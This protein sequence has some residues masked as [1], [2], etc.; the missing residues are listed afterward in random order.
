MKLLIWYWGRKGGGAKYS[1]EIAKSFINI[2]KE[3]TFLSF[4]KQ[5]EV[6]NNVDKLTQN[7]LHIKTYEN[8]LQFIIQTMLLPILI[9]RFIYFIRKNKIDCVV[10]TMPHI[11]TIA[12]LPFLNIFNIKHVVTI[13]DATSH[14]GDSRI[15]NIINPILIKLSHKIIVLSKHVQQELERLYSIDTSKL[16][17][18]KHGILSYKNLDM[19]EKD[20]LLNDG[21]RLIFFGRIEKYKG[22]QYLLKAQIE[23]EKKYNNIYL[24]IYGSGDLSAYSHLIEQVK[25]KKIGGLMIMRYII[26]FHLLVLILLPTLKQA[27]L[28]QYQLH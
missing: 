16:I 2:D 18:S 19:K 17:L 25:Y 7:S 9:V 21:I 14:P 1:E 15:W 3:N 13:H 10:T 27:S 6:F 11:W 20:F 28:E 8:K 23:L 12:I 5:S 24:E 26:F 4:S 22:L